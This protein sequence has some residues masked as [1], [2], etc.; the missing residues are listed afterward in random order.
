M[1]SLV[2]SAVLFL[3]A[4]GI[5][6]VT[7]G[8]ADAFWRG[9]GYYAGYGYAGYYPAYSYGYYPAY[10][11]GYYPGYTTSSYYPGYSGYYSPG[12][13]NGSYYSGYSSLWRY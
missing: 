11:Y 4:L 10:S 1:R 9:Q 7:P 3:S 2:L 13:I 5:A 12:Y 6:F 8:T